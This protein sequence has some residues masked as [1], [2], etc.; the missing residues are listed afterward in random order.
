[1]ENFKH[2]FCES[3]IYHNKPEIINSLSSLYIFLLP[4]I[5]GNPKN[6]IL[7]NIS[8]LL[9]LNGLT[10][11][12]FHYNLNWLGKQLDEIPMILISYLSI[13]FLLKIYYNKDINLLNYYNYWNSFYVIMILTI[14]TFP[15]YSYLFP[16]LFGLY[17]FFAILLIHLVSVKF[18]IVYKK[19]LIKSGI[20]AL[21]WWLSELDCTKWTYIGHLFWHIL[22]PLGFYNLILKFDILADG[23][24]TFREFIYEL[25]KD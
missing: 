24:W 18:N 22:F 13:W 8:I 25:D 1:M 14:N 19:D 15:N 4:I 9:Q 21:L 11:C 17:I 20:G 5:Y 10:S 23:I 16:Y 3:R 6:D 12:Y 2:N 7:Y